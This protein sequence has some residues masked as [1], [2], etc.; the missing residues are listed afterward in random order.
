MQ[1]QHKKMKHDKPKLFRNKKAINDISII[2]IILTIFF[3]TAIIIPFVNAEFDTGFS[4][5]NESTIAQ[6]ARN[7]AESVT[8]ISAFTV[9]KNILK[10]SLFDI[11]NELGLPFWLDGL[12]TILAVIFILVVARNIWVGGGA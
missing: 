11:G 5:L 7:D 4:S 1:I 3:S 8:A 6:Q 2:A 10:L 12:Y 9:L